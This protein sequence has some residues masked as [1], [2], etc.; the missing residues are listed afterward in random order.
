MGRV[1]VQ[2]DINQ[3]EM[4]VTGSNLFSIIEG[5]LRVNHMLPR[6]PVLFYVLTTI[7]MILVVDLC[8]L[9]LFC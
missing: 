9:V 4:D 1:L 7:L 5:G 6:T 8:L 3:C 2:M